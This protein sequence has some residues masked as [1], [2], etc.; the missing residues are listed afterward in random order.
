MAA[1]IAI[2]D[3]IDIE[4]PE[5]A[6]PPEQVG[7]YRIFGE[8]ASGGMASVYLAV[9][10]HHGSTHTRTAA[11]RAIKRVHPH[12][13]QEREFVE[14]FIDEARIATRIRH[15][16]VGH[17][18]EWGESAG[19]FFLAM[20]L[21]RGETAFAILRRIAKA[22][23][24]LSN[25]AWMR[26]AAHIIKE[27]CAGLHA[28]HELEDED[29]EKLNVV[30]RDVSPH[31]IFV[32]WEGTAKIVDF[33]IASAKHCLHRTSAGTLKGKFAYM[34]PEQLKGRAIDRR[35]D[36]FSLGVVLWELLAGR[37]LFRRKTEGETLFAVAS[38]S[39]PTF[40]SLGLDVPF[41]FEAIVRRALRADPDRRTESAR[42]LEMQ[43]ESWIGGATTR[44]D[45]A[46]FIAE[47]FPRGPEAFDERIE[48]A[49]AGS[50][51]TKA[52]VESEAPGISR[53]QR[54][55]KKRHARRIGLSILVLMGAVL[56]WPETAHRSPVTGGSAPASTSPS[57]SDAVSESV[58]VQAAPPASPSPPAPT[59]SVTLRERPLPTARAERT[60]SETAPTINSGTTDARRTGF[61]DVATRGGWA[62]VWFQGR[63]VGHT[64]GRFE[65]PAGRH[66][67]VLRHGHIERSARVRVAHGQIARVQVELGD[68]R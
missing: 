65:L 14:M 23:G 12:L 6:P 15:P 45:V 39:I 26:C 2:D 63:R 24:M 17:V 3:D 20:E 41:E 61:V 21:L 35:A 25:P 4:M 18:C 51:S 7:R 16:N 64:P 5:P 32:T 42:A 11:L 46:T 47:L 22:G 57:A 19:T 9:E 34:A 56:A 38:A 62:E 66:T 55:K 60:A 40:A 31:N 50:T 67:L 54:T 37:A 68:E 13:A 27:A 8:I 48:R 53:V 58:P 36:V 29:G 30:H 59:S 52:C 49:L 10:E 44:A 1:A 28:A 43:L 33:G